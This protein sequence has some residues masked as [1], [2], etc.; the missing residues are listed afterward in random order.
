M[1]DGLIQ[2]GVARKILLVTAETYSKYID[3]DDRSLRTIF[4]D[5]AA[6]T[7][8]TAAA[9][10]WIHVDIASSI[11]NLAKEKTLNDEASAKIF[12]SIGR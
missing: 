9:P 3:P 1:A 11:N 5:G 12:E 10:T 2:S 6:A 4:G 8:I 7:L